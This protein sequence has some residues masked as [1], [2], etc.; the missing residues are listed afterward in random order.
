M[1]GA[2]SSA[3][4]SALFWT[5]LNTA[6]AGQA[7]MPRPLSLPDLTLNCFQSSTTK[8][9]FPESKHAGGEFSID[10]DNFDKPIPRYRLQVVDRQI[11]KVIEDP[12][13]PAMR[14]ESGVQVSNMMRDFTNKHSIVGWQQPDSISGVRTFILNFDDLLLSVLRVSSA[15]VHPAIAGVAMTVL[16]CRKA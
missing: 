9:P 10:G 16:R 14:K 1:K 11:L 5:A 4:V 13:R 8:V 3:L 7:L 12:S 15:N 2:L 6:A